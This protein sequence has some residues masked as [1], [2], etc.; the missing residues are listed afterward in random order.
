MDDL[1]ESY[2]RGKAGFI[3]TRIE[4]DYWRIE[5]ATTTEFTTVLR[6]DALLW[7]TTFYRNGQIVPVEQVQ[8]EVFGP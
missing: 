7:K 4:F 6:N 2:V 3:Y 5:N 8:K 1:R